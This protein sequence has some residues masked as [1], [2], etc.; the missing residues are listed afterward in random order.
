M[1]VFKNIG[2]MLV[3]IGGV[4]ISI[5]ALLNILKY[6]IYIFI[7]N[8]VSSFINIIE[9]KY[10]S[11]YRWIID[12]FFLLGY[13]ILIPIIAVNIAILYIGY[14][15]YKIDGANIAVEAR[16][17][18]IIVITVFLALSLFLGSLL[19]SISFLLPL[20]GFIIISLKHENIAYKMR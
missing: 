19:S 4:M 10:I 5:I 15:L 17:K 12:W 18:W 8:F 11:M 16:D 14:K 6:S 7:I 1:N 13:G 2:G 9:D 20:I 3:K